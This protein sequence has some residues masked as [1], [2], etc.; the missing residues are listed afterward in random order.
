MHDAV[1]IFG[2][3][4]TIHQGLKELNMILVKISVG[5]KIGKRRVRK[6]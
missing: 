1:L 4:D 5:S 2:V 6:L 3:N